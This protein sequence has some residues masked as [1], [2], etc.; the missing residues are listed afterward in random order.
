MNNRF[1]LVTAAL[2]GVDGRFQFGEH[3][4]E[5][6]NRLQGMFLAVAEHDQV[7]RVT[8]KRPHF[9]ES[10]L[11]YRIQGMQVDVGEQRRDH[12]TFG[13]SD[14]CFLYPTF[15]HHPCCQPLPD[16][17]QY[18]PIAYP[19]FHELHQLFVPDI[20]KIS[21]DI[22]VHNPVNPPVVGHVHDS[23]KRI[24]GASLRPKSV[25]AVFEVRFIDALQYDFGCAKPA[26]S[27]AA[28]SPARPLARSFT[29]KKS[30]VLQLSVF[31]TTPRTS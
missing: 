21:L 14:G 13:A 5:Y 24:M 18:L 6:S 1:C 8:D 3:R 29:L 17:L 19:L 30:S 12:P 27:C 9:L 7:I 20:D 4:F 31:L 10:F 15:L 16:E 11:P 22:H 2:L 23:L 26:V 28:Y 25:G